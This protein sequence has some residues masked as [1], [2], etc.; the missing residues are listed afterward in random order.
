MT[1]RTK[2][3]G[4]AGRF[5]PK[6]GV[7]IRKQIAAIEKN[8]IKRHAC[9]RCLHKSVKRVETSVWN[10]RHCGLTFASGAYSPNLGRV[11]YED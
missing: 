10:C 1:R 5:G 6:Y 8:K 9:P 11:K 2:K 7:K 3:I 4:S